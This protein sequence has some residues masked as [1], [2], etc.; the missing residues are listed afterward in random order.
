MEDDG[1]DGPGPSHRQRP[2][3]Q[4]S[5]KTA[6]QVAGEAVIGRLVEAVDGACFSFK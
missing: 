3:A 4:P 2:P 6:Q 5:K 1:D